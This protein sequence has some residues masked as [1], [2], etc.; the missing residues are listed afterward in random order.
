MAVRWVS[1]S[2]AAIT[3]FHEPDPARRPPGSDAV[4]TIRPEN[5]PDCPLAERREFLYFCRYYKRGCLEDH[6][7]KP[8]YCKVETIT[9]EEGGT[10]KL[11]EKN[12]DKSLD[13]DMHKC[14][15]LILIAILIEIL[16]VVLIYP[17]S[18][19]PS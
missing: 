13:V 17:I 16:I 4:T 9:I 10:R 6:D 3:G 14:R 11:K 2:A 15:T 1:A 18:S 8:P 12:D 7:N 19:V 5:C